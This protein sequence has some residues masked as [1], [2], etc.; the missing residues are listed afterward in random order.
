MAAY[1]AFALFVTMFLPWYSKSAIG[2]NARGMP[3]KIVL[4]RQ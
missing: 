3:V 2:V 4:W 1:A